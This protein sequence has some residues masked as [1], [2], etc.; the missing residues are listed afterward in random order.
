MEGGPSRQGESV[1]RREF[2]AMLQD[3]NNGANQYSASLTVIPLRFA[4]SSS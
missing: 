4:Q 1:A 3:H 2:D